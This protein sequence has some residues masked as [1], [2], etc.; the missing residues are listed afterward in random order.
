[1][2]S[3]ARLQTAEGLVK[4]ELYRLADDG[5]IPNNPTLPLL[6]YRAVLRHRGEDAAEECESLFAR[7]G[8]CGGWHNGIYA[9]H[10]YHPNAH[11]VL[12]IVRGAARVR[13]GGDRGPLL[14]LDTGDVQR[15]ERAAPR[16]RAHPQGAAALGRPDLRPP[17]AAARRLVPP[18]RRA[19]GRLLRPCQVKRPSTTSTR[20]SRLS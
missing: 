7:N 16:A 10:H 3:V 17:G 9:Y 4:P 13:F 1:M 8:W 6:V 14:S 11:E 19:A 2:S 18:P 20:G 15:R 5:R 12:G